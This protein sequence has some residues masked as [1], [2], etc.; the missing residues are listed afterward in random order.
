MTGLVHNTRKNTSLHPKYGGKWIIPE[1]VWYETALIPEATSARLFSSLLT[2]VIWT[3][4][5]IILFGKSHP[6][7]RL[8]AWYGEPGSDYS[9]SGLKLRPMP[10]SEQL[11]EIKAV[12]EERV[13]VFFNSLLLNQYRNGS[14][15]MGWHADDE[16]ELG[17]QPVIASVSLG[18]TRRFLLRQR[19]ASGKRKSI[20][21]DLTSGSLLVMSGNCQTE[22]KH[23]IPKTK[24]DVG[25]RINLTFRRI[26]STSD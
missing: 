18:E 22:F 4:H 9:Y 23:S 6:C 3:Q 10:W 25:V 26:V 12:V 15:S 24:R 13:G 19:H 7:P 21:V 17:E 1:A 8:S 5:R 2:G 20:S 11:L 14:D 16:P